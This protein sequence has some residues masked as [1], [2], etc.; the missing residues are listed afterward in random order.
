M[1]HI[2]L[3]RHAKSD[4]SEPFESDEKRGLSERGKKQIKALRH[5]LQDY[6]LDVDMALVS[7]AVRAEKTYH[8]LRK[9]ILRLPKPDVIPSIYESDAEDLLFLCQGIPNT[10]RSIL[11]VGHNPG[12]ED[13]ALMLVP[14]VKGDALRD[15]LEMKFPTA[16][17]A[18]MPEIR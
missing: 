7:Q 1:K 11:I 8:H 5:F 2:Y 10:V 15:S 16:S 12:L 9:E 6:Q 17:L 13:L 18:E 4:W 3:L 14:D